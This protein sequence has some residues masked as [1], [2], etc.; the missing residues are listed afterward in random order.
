MRT[1]I[2]YFERTLCAAW[3][4]FPRSNQRVSRSTSSTPS[5]AMRVTSAATMIMVRMEPAAARRLAAIQ[6]AS[7]DKG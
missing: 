3:C 7:D 4:G 5:T 1:I 2:G 6:D